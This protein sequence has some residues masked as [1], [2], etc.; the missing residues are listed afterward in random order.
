MAHVMKLVRYGTYLTLNKN[1]EKLDLNILAAAFE[2][3]VQADKPE[4]NNPFL[5]D[6]FEIEPLHSATLDL[7]VGGTNKRLKSK[8]KDLR[9]SQILR[10][11]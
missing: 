8:Y 11:S 1:Q 2:K 10:N 3:F 5:T 9:A 4:K 6:K 7:E